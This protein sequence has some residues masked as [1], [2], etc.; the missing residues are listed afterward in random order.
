MPTALTRSTLSLATLTSAQPMNWLDRV[1]SCLR[2][3]KKCLSN[4]DKTIFLITINLPPSKSA[5]R[6]VH[7]LPM[8]LS[9]G[10]G[11]GIGMDLSM[12]GNPSHP[13][14]CILF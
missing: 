12:G 5:W 9:M 14:A 10:L 11:L 3:S 8:D 6:T 2:H 4:I 7:I 1:E 13:N